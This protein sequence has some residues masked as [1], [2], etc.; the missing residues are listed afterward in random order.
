MYAIIIYRLKENLLCKENTMGLG[1]LTWEKWK[2]NITWEC[3]VD[4]PL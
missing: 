1:C 2:W 4:L 3:M